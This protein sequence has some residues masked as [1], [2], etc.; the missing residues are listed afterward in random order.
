MAASWNERGD[1]P[2]GAGRRLKPPPSRRAAVAAR[3]PT[4]LLGARSRFPSESRISA[5]NTTSLRVG[6]GAAA[7]AATSAFFIELIALDDKK[8]RRRDDE[9]IDD[10]GGEIAIGEHAAL[11]LRIDEVGGGDRV[12]QRQK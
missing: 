1:P 2:Q 7:G 5:N 4:M 11:L 8:Q 10:D 6:G 3:S 9:E 12:R